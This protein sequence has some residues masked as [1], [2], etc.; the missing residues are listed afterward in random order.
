MYDCH[1][2]IFAYKAYSDMGAL[3]AERT[4][5]SVPFGAKYRVIDFALSSL[6]NA[7][8]FDVGVIMQRNFQS[9]L[10]HIG[11][12]K[13]WDMSRKSGGLRILPPFSMPRDHDGVYT[14]TV[15]ALN[16]VYSYVED[17][18][19][20]TVVLMQGN[21]VANVDL[22]D[23]VASHKESGC[24]ITA[25]CAEA[26]SGDTRYY[27]VKGEDGCA[28]KIYLDK[29]KNPDALHSLE[30]Y[31]INKDVL[32]TMLDSCRNENKYR[33]HSDAIMGLLAAGGKMNVYVHKGYAAVIDSVETFYKAS[34]EL[35]L[36]ETRES[37]FPEDRPIRT[38]SHE[39]VS[40]FYGEEAVCS[41]SA[42]ADNCII[43]GKIKNCIV[44]SGVVIGK[45]AEVT[46]CVL[47]RGTVVGE[48]AV[49]KNI[50]ADKSCV[51]PDNTTLIGSNKLP[52]VCPKNSRL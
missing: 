14:G 11:S 28:E 6:R 52:M 49:L 30:L 24:P 17:I 1:G 46:N 35:L 51:F 44:H 38:F 9:L 36:K 32:M 31:V 27:Y 13:V 48:N 22:A 5:S 20:D 40:T 19:Q 47:M 7:G 15:E 45:G 10:D 18:K 33:F 4:V 2:I 50:I 39:E 25:V 21:M 34:S 12:G 42:V 3:C 23:I 26:V 8:I 43:E 16:A 41:T 29:N 37:L